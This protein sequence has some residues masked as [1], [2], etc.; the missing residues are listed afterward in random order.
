[1]ITRCTERTTEW[2][3]KHK[4]VKSGDRALYEYAVYSLVIS[5]SPLIFVMVIGALTG[6]LIRGIVMLLP[7]LC[8]RK[9]SGGFH[10]KH[11]GSC[12]LISSALLT[13]CMWLINVLQCNG[14]L[15][16]ITGWAIMSL[17]VCSPVESE[18]RRLEKEERK[19]YKVIA[20]ILACVFGMIYTVLRLC[21]I[22]EYAVCIFMGIV[23]SAILQV[24]CYI[25]KFR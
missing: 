9:F 16:V 14:I 5:V 23:L 11:A 21:G 4:A 13:F 25:K 1:M 15:D 3:I 7:F 19:Q 8:I 18:N 2:L 6:N 12:F 20:R 10:A 17:I 22:E 24:P